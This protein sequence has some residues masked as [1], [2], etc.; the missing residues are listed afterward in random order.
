MILSTKQRY[1]LLPLLVLYLTAGDAH[2]KTLKK[3]GSFLTGTSNA[4]YAKKRSSV[5]MH[6]ETIYFYY[7]VGNVLFRNA[8]GAPF[9]YRLEV[10]RNMKLV[11][12]TKWIADMAEEPDSSFDNRY[13]KAYANSKT[14]IHIDDSFRT[15]NYTAQI[16]FRDLN[17]GRETNFNYAF[18]LTRKDLMKDYLR[19][20][21]TG[22][23]NT[24]WG[25][26]EL[27]Q[28]GYRIR[29]YFKKNNGRLEGYIKD[30]RIWGDWVMEPSYRPPLDQGKFV[31]EFSR[32]GKKLFGQYRNIK[33]RNWYNW[34]GYLIE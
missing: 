6:G 25:V 31:F 18:S 23:Y 2:S 26:L 20:D 5:V 13:I 33:D 29:G 10:R 17:T 32:D 8:N 15:G 34:N 22:L 3:M 11:I 16:F 7:K 12:R 4:D 1:F 28:S 30:F 9:E 21:V 14:N 24:S 27:I 19:S